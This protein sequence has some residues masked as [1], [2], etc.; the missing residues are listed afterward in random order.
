MNDFTKEDLNNIKILISKT[1]ITGND[2]VAV[3]VLQQK[4]DK[5]LVDEKSA[6]NPKDKTK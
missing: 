5:L 4:I 2:A 3:A 1:P 6:E